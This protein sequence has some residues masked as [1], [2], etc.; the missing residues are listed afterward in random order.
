MVIALGFVLSIVNITL[1]QQRTLSEITYSVQA[2]YAAEAG[3]EDALLRLQNGMN[4]SS[5]YSFEVGNASSTVTI[6]SMIGGVRTIDAE[7]DATNR[8]RKIQTV[9]QLV[10]E[11]TSFNFGA[12]VGDWGLEMRHGAGII[13][14]NV[15]SNNTIFGIGTASGTAIVAGIGNELRDINVNENA[16]AYSCSGATIL[17]NLEYNTAGTNSCTFGTT[18]TTSDAIVP[19]PFPVTSTM[20]TDWKNDAEAGGVIIGDV[21][22]SSAT[23]LGPIKIDGNLTVEIGETLTLNGTVW[24]TGTSLLRNSA[25]LRLDE[26]YGDL[27]GVLISDGTVQIRNLVTLKGTTSPSSFFTLIGTSSSIDESNAA[28]DVKNN[29]DGAILFTPNG[30]MVLHNNTNLVEVTA[31]KLLLHKTTLIYEVGLQDIRFTSGPSAGWT[32]TRWR[33]VK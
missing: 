33:E 16:E 1:N 25:T 6:S 24:V 13:I 17:G 15:F 32:V 9:Y 23:S 3:V 18:S 7:G 28:M 27:S 10:S 22:I 4:W 26:G 14:G 31:Y 19:L 29:A 2:Y 11:G 20:I 30:L 21:S 8:I 5:S 12:Q